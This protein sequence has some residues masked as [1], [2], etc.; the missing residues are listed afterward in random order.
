MGRGINP[1]GSHPRFPHR[2]GPG[3]LSSTYREIED[4]RHVQRH[5]WSD[6]VHSQSNRALLFPPTKKQ[7]ATVGV[8]SH[9]A[10]LW[11]LERTVTTFD[12]IRESHIS[13]HGQ[14]TQTGLG[15]D[16]AG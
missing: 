2:R 7:H 16:Q 6:V 5:C 12:D 10:I 15:E 9:A 14:S 1:K 3:K 8:K 4:Q 13:H 11:N